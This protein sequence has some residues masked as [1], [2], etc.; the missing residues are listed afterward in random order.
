MGQ[1]YQGRERIGSNKE[2]DSKNGRRLTC[3]R[4][5]KESEEEYKICVTRAEHRERLSE[6]ACALIKPM[7][8]S[9]VREFRECHGFG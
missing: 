5:C 9:R 6:G 8:S 2:R 1:Q 4:I 3:C 7:E